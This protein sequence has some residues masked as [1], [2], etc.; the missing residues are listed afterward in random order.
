MENVAVLVRD[1]RVLVLNLDQAQDVKEIVSQLKS[2]EKTE[3]L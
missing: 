3:L 2:A 1:G